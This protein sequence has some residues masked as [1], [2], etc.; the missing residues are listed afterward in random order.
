[1][2]P[3]SLAKELATLDDS[4]RSHVNT[5]ATRVSA[6]LAERKAATVELRGANEVRE[7]L[8]RLQG[9]VATSHEQLAAIVSSAHASDADL[10]TR[11][12]RLSSLSTASSE[13]RARVAELDSVPRSGRLPKKAQR[14]LES[15]REVAVAAVDELVHG[16]REAQKRT[17]EELET[18][19]FQADS[20]RQAEEEERAARAAAEELARDE[21]EE[22]ERVER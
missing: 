15:L 12:A 5:L 14:T 22:E 6:L 3:P 19:T 17:E 9:E 21:E 10:R 11:Q 18:M 4:V 8:V 16:I 1:M 20:Q 13:M 2:L 7:G